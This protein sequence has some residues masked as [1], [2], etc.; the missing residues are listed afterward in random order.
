MGNS[1]WQENNDYYKLEPVTVEIIKKAEEKLKIKLP[2]TYIKILKEQ[3]GGN[4][5]F[6]SFPSEVPTSWAD[7]H[8]NVDHILGIGEEKGILESEYLIQEWGLPNNIVLISGDGHSWI[9]LDYRNTIEEPPVIFIDVDE[10]QIINLAPNFEMFLNGLT[11]WE[12]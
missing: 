4:I 9:A 2:S 3:N 8:I 1:I 5:K 11:V 12:D 10:E 7:D 6:D